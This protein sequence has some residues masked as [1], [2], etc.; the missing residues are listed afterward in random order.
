[1]NESCEVSESSGFVL[2]G[3]LFEATPWPHCSLK[4]PTWREPPG[5]NCNRAMTFRTILR[6]SKNKLAGTSES[7]TEC[8]GSREVSGWQAQDGAWLLGQGL[9]LVQ[10]GQGPTSD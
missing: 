1:M 2:G 10:R 3:H 4:W 8:E 5:F 9:A 7:L 6:G